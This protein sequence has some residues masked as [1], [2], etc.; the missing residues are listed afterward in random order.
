MAV[1]C[2]F[3]RIY[4]DNDVVHDAIHIPVDTCNDNAIITSICRIDAI[5]SVAN[6]SSSG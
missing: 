6:S 3:H 5:N 2:K 1:R 4:E